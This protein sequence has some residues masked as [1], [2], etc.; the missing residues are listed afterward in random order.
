MPHRQEVET[1][2]LPAKSAR[3]FFKPGP[4]SGRGPFN[5]PYLL[6]RLQEILQGRLDGMIVAGV[7]GAML[8]LVRGEIRARPR[9]L[10]VVLAKSAHRLEDIE[11]VCRHR[12]G[13]QADQVAERRMAVVITVAMCRARLQEFCSV[14]EAERGG[15]DAGF[16]TRAVFAIVMVPGTTRCILISIAKAV[17]AM[18]VVMI[19]CSTARARGSVST[20][21]T[22][23]TCC[24]GRASRTC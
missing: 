2:E 21:R 5:F 17:I 15:G 4:V 19:T 1:R 9:R 13:R 10:V 12:C 3:P 23:R 16:V 7:A 6:M 14:L 24:S 11:Q 18:V 22:S 20:C 8:G